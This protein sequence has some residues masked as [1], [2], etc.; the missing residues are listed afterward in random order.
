MK[1]LLSFILS[2]GMVCLV[3]SAALSWVNQTTLEPIEKAQQA[4]LEA[5]LKLVLPETMTRTEEVPAE[6]L[7]EPAKDKQGAVHLYQAFDE[8]G[9]LVGYA[10]SAISPVGG[11]KGPIKVVAGINLDGKI[12]GVM[13]TEHSET[14][15]IGTKVTDRK[16]V[17]SLWDVLA[18]KAHEEKFPPNEFLDGQFNGTDTAKGYAVGGANGANAVVAVSG[19]TYSS[20]SVISAVDAIGRAF[21]NF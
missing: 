16:S 14:P 12:R 19:A 3:A 17:K 13:I 18:G 5:S 21:R 11:F 10:A 6:K 7:G 1:Q 8:K 20:R 15:G 9:T 4:A 2:L